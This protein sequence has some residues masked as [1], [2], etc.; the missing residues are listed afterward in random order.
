MNYQISVKNQ[1]KNSENQSCIDFILSNRP[2]SF[3]KTKTVF[4]GLSDF[5]KLVFISKFS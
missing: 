4:P 5:H 1:H 2:K 3:V